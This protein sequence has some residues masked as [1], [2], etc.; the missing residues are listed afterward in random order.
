MSLYVTMIDKFMSGWGPA[1][2]RK[3]IY[4]VECDSAAQADVIARAASRRPEM[5]GIRVQRERPEDSP[6]QVV[7]H[8]S[9]SELGQIWTGE[10]V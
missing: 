9:F 5:A 6:L 1:E 2:G 8:K 4:C 3:N 10:N 7:T